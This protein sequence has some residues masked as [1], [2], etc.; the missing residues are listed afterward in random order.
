MLLSVHAA[1]MRSRERRQPENCFRLI[2]ENV[3]WWI[4]GDCVCRLSAV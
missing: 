4:L 2:L 3:R 1:P